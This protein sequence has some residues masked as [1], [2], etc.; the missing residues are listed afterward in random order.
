LALSDR[1]FRPLFDGLAPPLPYRWVNPPREVARDNQQPVPAS[2]ETPLGTNGSAFVNVTP[3]DGQV[4]L[5]LEERVVPPRPPDTAVALTVT[6]LD[7][8]TLGPLPDDMT[9]ASNAYRVEATYRPSAQPVTDFEVELSS[10]SLVAAAP[11]DALLY[12][13]DGQVWEA[14]PTMPLGTVHGLETPFAG[15]GYYV[16]T[17]IDDAAGGG[18]TGA[19]AAVV[20]LVLVLPP[21]LV[22]GLV[23]RSRRARAAAEAAAEAEAAAVAKRRAQQ[24]KGGRKSK[25]P[26]R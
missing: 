18:G 4:I 24:R 23:L 12:S 10:I 5:V 9:Q 21:L 19:S 13:A 16:V 14:R 3:D 2:G 8:L 15:P 17:D 6:P 26:R 11:S 22:V 1:P 20:G 25:R 7:V